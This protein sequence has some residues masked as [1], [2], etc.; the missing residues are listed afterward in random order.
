MTANKASMP[1]DRGCTTG[2]RNGPEKKKKRKME[3]SV[4]EHAGCLEEASGA[5]SQ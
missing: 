3:E 2:S 5:I 1:D 4:N